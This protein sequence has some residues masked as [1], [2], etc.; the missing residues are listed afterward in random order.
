MKSYQITEWCQESFKIYAKS[1]GIYIDATMGNGNDTLF[2]CRMAGRTGHVKAFDIQRQ[3]LE[4]TE[5]LLQENGVGERA[6]LFLDSHTNMGLYQQEETVDGIFFNFGYLPGGD[7]SL[8]TKPENSMKAVLTGLGLLKKGGVMSLCIYSGGHTG[9]EERDKILEMLKNLDS[10]KYVVI[11][12]TYYNREN[13][14]PI[15]VLIIK[16]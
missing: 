11:L 1:G 12:S 16:K 14:P 5:K 13:N 8:A 9:F 15:P 2:L 6:E 3:A 10:R 4:A 7:H